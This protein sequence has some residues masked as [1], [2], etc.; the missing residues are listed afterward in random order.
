MVSDRMIDCQGPG[1]LGIG[2]I[3]LAVAMLSWIACACA[4]APSGPR[5]TIAQP[6]TSE[7]WW[8]ARHRELCARA[9]KEPIDILFLGDS[10]TQ[11]WHGTGRDPYEGDGLAIWQEFYE[12]RHAANF[13]MGSDRT[14][15]LLW[16]IEHGELGRAQPH[17]VVLL[18]G[19]NN[20]ATDTPEEVAMGVAAV[21]KELLRRLPRTRVLLLG[22]L[23]RGVVRDANLERS[24][25]DPRVASANRLIQAEKRDSRVTYVD[26]GPHFLS[27]DHSISIELMPDFLH[28][29]REGYR[30]WAVAMEPD[31][32][33]LLTAHG[34]R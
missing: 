31:L 32:R 24:A 8:L 13:G 17:V 33:R 7:A 34:A 29:G 5:S 28:L 20:L 4:K 3:V 9:Q 30:R 2:K 26:L 19:T 6:R 10:I 18:I 16:R 15:N 27:D 14:E 22:I 11:G 1:G 25:A 23:P 12:P 21:V